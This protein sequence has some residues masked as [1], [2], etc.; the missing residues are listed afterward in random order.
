[1]K[2][3]MHIYHAVTEKKKKENEHKISTF[4]DMV[5]DAGKSFKDDKSVDEYLAESRT[6]R[7]FN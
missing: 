4:V 7:K 5:K 2:S 6:D 1:M 3:D